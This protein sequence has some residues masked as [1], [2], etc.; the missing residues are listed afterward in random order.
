[1]AEGNQLRR[2]GV[3]RVLKGP[4][5]FVDAALKYLKY[6]IGIPIPEETTYIGIP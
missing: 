4:A 6:Y 5:A 3:F 1:M 2:Y